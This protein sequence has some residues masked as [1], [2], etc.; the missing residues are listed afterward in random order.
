MNLLFWHNVKMS[1]PCN[2]KVQSSW[3]AYVY[4]WGSMQMQLCC[5]YSALPAEEFLEDSFDRASNEAKAAFGDGRMFIEKYV[6]SPRHIEVQILADNHGNVVHLYERDCSVQRRHQKVCFAALP[7][8][9]LPYLALPCP[10]PSTL[11]CPG[12]VLL[13]CLL[14]SCAGLPRPGLPPALPCPGEC[15]QTALCRPVQACS[16]LPFAIM[17]SLPAPLIC[18]V[19]KDAIAVTTIEV[20]AEHTCL[21]SGDGSSIWFG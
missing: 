18:L 16:A 4:P 21:G 20:T 11:P 10:A 15:C 5:P 6:E 7:C 19:H 9:A 1:K 12:N 8:P 13:H 14:L 2:D 3:I 17:F